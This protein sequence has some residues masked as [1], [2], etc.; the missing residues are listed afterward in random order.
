[1]T[2]RAGDVFWA[3]SDKRRPV[4][5]VSREELNRGS[6]VVVVPLTTSNLETRNRLAN[7]VAISGA[8]YG[9]RD[10]VAQAGMV[11]VLMRSDLLHVAD[12]PI[13]RLKSRTIRDLIRAVGYVMAAECEPV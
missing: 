9:L 4:V 7:C 11:T 3:F 13:A 8:E 6:Y 10:C 12:G 5:V 1:M 2:P